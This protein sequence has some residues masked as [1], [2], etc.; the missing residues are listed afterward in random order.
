M[1]DAFEPWFCPT[2]D[3][4]RRSRLERIGSFDEV[5]ARL[6]SAIRRVAS[7]KK[8]GQDEG[9]TEC[10][11]PVFTLFIDGESFDSF[12]NAQCGY[13]AQYARDA[14]LG[15]AANGRLMHELMDRLLEQA[16]SDSE[17][18]ALPVQ[19]SLEAA[20]AKIWPMDDD[21]AF[22]HFRRDLCVPQWVR[23][24]DRGNE[25]AQMGLV[26]PEAAILEIKGALLDTYG[27][28]VVPASKIQRRQQIHEHGFS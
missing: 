27:H 25:D 1:S 6:Q 18:A 11:Q 13:R 7:R 22:T 24:A 16:A 26:A 15:L 8:P 14:D 21:L 20:S 3:S 19:R 5:I 10:W 9:L 23:A 17:L 28:E 4:V 12:F 2:F